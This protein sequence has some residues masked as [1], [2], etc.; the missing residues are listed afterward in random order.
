MVR[1]GFTLIRPAGSIVI[2]GKVL[3]GLVGCDRYGSEACY[4]GAYDANTAKQLW[5]FYTIARGNDPGSDTW[6]KLADNLRI[7][8]FILSGLMCFIAAVL[9][10]FIGVD[11]RKPEPAAQAA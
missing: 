4:I 11:W 2:N 6:G 1:S 5:K 10:M 7:G 3:Q 9:V 8:A